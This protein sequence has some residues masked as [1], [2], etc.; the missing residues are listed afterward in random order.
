MIITKQHAHTHTL[1]RA[2]VCVAW[3]SFCTFFFSV[4]SVCVFIFTAFLPSQIAAI[5]RAPLANFGF[6]FL[7][8]NSKHISIS[9]PPESKHTVQRLPMV[10]FALHISVILNNARMEN[11]HWNGNDSNGCSG[12]GIVGIGCIPSMKD[13]IDTT[14][15]TEYTVRTTHWGCLQ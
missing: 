13:L 6:N 7:L 2:S 3:F 11:S 8:K 10:Y 4:N 14:V 9:S 5:D 15:A 12:D 1:T